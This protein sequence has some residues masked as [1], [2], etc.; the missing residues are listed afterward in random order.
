MAPKVAPS[1]ALPAG[2]IVSNYKL[3]VGSYL[4]LQIACWVLALT[5]VGGAT[6]PHAFA[7]VEAS[8]PVDV[9][10]CLMMFLGT[11]H[12]GLL[13]DDR[14][15]IVCR[16]AFL[17]DGTALLINHSVIIRP[18]SLADALA[19]ANA[20]LSEPTWSNAWR[21]LTAGYWWLAEGVLSAT[22]GV[23][24]LASIRRRVC[25][26]AAA[27]RAAFSAHFLRVYCAMLALQVGLM[28]WAVANIA[29]ATTTDAEILATKTNDA[30]C[31]LSL[32]LAQS[33]AMK[34][35]IFDATGRTVGQ[36]VT[37]KGST[38]SYV[39]LVFWLIWIGCILTGLLLCLSAS[40]SGDSA[41]LV[42][43]LLNQG[44]VLAIMPNFLVWA[45]AGFNM[46]LSPYHLVSVETG[47]RKREAGE[48]FFA[49]WRA[50]ARKVEV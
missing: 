17:V 50:G 46:G 19:Y 4:A 7:A 18:M 47:E 36:F 39:A 40:S 26:G 10:F 29:S 28:A 3:L 12:H 15:R 41:L 8:L 11:L 43:D 38:A 20:T 16:I 44:P 30:L 48:N 1:D 49:K 35:A 2:D 23:N 22:I 32:A 6:G 5:E 27:D 45:T 25:D 37:G 31:S 34:C 14:L 21:Y 13:P 9:T 33:Y 24:V 42:A